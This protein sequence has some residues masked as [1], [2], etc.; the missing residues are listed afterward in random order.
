[1]DTLETSELMT[2]GRFAR[3]TGLT[4]K[5]LRHYD[6]V[7]LLRPATVDS[8]TGYRSYSSGQVR[9]AERI[10][11]L[12]RLELPLDDVATLVESEDPTLIHRVL[13]DHQRRTASRSAE[14][15][16]VLQGLQPLIDGKETVMKTPVEAIDHRRL[17]VD[18]FN[19]TWTLME[20]DDRTEAEDDELVH[21]AHASAYHWLHVGT[22]A[23]RARSEWQCSRMYTVLGRAEPALHHARRCLELCE[24]SPEALEDWDLPYAHEAL[25]RAHALAAETDEASRHAAQARELAARVADAEDRE[26][27]EA[28]LATL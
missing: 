9:R 20:K 17:G 23:N 28:D 12:R 14:L 4:V 26:H 27:L 24:A 21:C 18:L 3:I 6:E 13:V 5:A 7:G 19:K 22:P 16:V 15:K 2:I 1:M 25:A 10:R 11:M 8:E